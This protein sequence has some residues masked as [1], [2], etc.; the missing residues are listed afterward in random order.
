MQTSA[1]ERQRWRRE[2]VDQFLHGI[3][4]ECG[5]LAG[6]TQTCLNEWARQVKLVEDQP[7]SNFGN[8]VMQLCKAV[9]SELST[10]LG[11]IKALAFLR[12]GTLGQK[13]KNLEMTNLD[14]SPKQGLI[15]RGI[16]PGFVTS[17]LPKLLS[18]L[19]HLRSNTG[20]AHGNTE[21]RSANAHDAALARKLAGQI[22]QGIAARPKGSK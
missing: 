16:K 7:S 4:L 2:H 11:S 17:T 13:A 1:E 19:A 6:S 20:A 15:S 12:E 8:A 10:G 9:E 5:R 14:D 21:I 3:G 18:S 22:L